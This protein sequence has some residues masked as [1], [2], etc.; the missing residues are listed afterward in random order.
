MLDPRPVPLE[1]LTLPPHTLPSRGSLVLLHGYGAN[2]HDLLQLGPELAPDRRTVSLQAPLALPWG[3][4]AWFNLR[5]SAGGFE[6]DPAEIE[7]ALAQTLQAVEQVAREDGTPPL[8]LG[9]SQGASLALMV[10]LQQP[11]LVRGVLSLSGVPPR[12]AAPWQAN[13][14]AF[15]GFPVFGAHGTQDPLLPIAL[16]RSV[17]AGLE[18]AGCDL[19][20]REYVMGHEVVIDELSDARAWIVALKAWP[21]AE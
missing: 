13:A 4:R 11:R 9:F 18:G 6:F 3:G 12:L 10:A 14:L 21:P 19:T 2:E 16:G 8:L 15:K 20:W 5:E 1:R 17:R 7:R